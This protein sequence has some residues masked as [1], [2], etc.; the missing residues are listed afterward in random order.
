M[1]RHKTKNKPG[2]GSCLFIVLIF[3]AICLYDPGD[4]T[5]EQKLERERQQT[6]DKS[7]AEKKK[8]AAEKV[9]RLENEK[10]YE[11][12]RKASEERDRIQAQWNA[13]KTHWLNGL[14]DVRHNRSCQYFNN[15]DS[16]RY[17][18]PGEGRACKNCG[19]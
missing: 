19:G 6:V 1:S 7:K 9:Q 4:I 18:G 16:G 5:P 2:C 10:Y 8:K 11:E 14:T 12:A 13:Q 3:A 17:C 15:T